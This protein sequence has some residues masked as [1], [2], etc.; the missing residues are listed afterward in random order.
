MS[1]AVVCDGLWLLHF[2]A[3]MRTMD[4]RK[5]RWRVKDTREVGGRA[6]YGYEETYVHVIRCHDMHRAHNPRLDALDTNIREQ[7]GGAEIRWATARHAK[8]MSAAAKG[9]DIHYA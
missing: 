1:A 3:V 7:P 2:R 4:G 6:L 8:T 9:A 5:T